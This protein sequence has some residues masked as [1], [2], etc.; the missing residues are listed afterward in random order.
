MITEVHVHHMYCTRAAP[1]RTRDITCTAKNGTRCHATRAV[2]LDMHRSMHVKTCVAWRCHARE[3][4]EIAKASTCACARG[5][6]YR[7]SLCVHVCTYASEPRDRT[8][9]NDDA[10]EAA[11]PQ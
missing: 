10:A 5:H 3:A 2:D 7:C 1:W 6:G 4:A 8:H 9:V 11:E